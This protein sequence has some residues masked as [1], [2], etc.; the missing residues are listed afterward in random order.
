MNW[1]L[2]LYE[3]YENYAEHE[4]E[5][6]ELL[7]PVAHT[8][9]Q[10]QIEI[11]LDGKGAF[12]RASVIEK[13]S[14]VTMIPC[15]EESGG[16]AGSKPVNHPLCDKLQYVA[17]D[18]V[19]FGGD[20]TSGFASNPAEPHAAFVKSLTAWA[21]SDHGH[22][23][24]DAIR[25]YVVGGR[26]IA[27]LVKAGVLPTDKKGKL[28]KAWDGVRGSTPTIFRV[29]Q[30][31][32]APGDAFVR[33]QVESQA[34]DAVSKTWNDPT[35]ASA[36]IDYYHAIQ[37]KR[38]YCMVTG[39]EAPLAIQHPARLRG[40][41]DKAKLISSN[42]TSGFTFRGKFIKADDAAGVSFDV[43]QKAHNALRWL[44]ARQG[45]VD[46]KRKQAVVS[47]VVAVKP[48]P[49]WFSSTLELCGLDGGALE[50]APHGADTDQA[51]AIRLKK[52]IAGYGASLDPTDVV[53]VMALDSAT[54]GRMAITFYR[55]LKGSEFLDR[56]QAW[57]A[58][59]AWP[60]NMGKE[61]KFVGAPSPRDIAEAAYHRLD[62]KLGK[63]TIE[64]LLP[65]IV[66][67][68]PI[69]HALVMSTTRRASNR[70]GLENWEWEKCLGIA[71]ALFKG[72]F[73]E[74]NYQMTLETNRTTRDY[75]YG[76]LLAIAEHIESHALYV[77]GENRNT[78]A[79]RLMQRFADRPYST[80]KTIE[81]SLT[82]YKTRLRNMRAGFLYKMEKDL[83][84]VMN[85]FAAE[86]FRRDTQLSGEFLLAYHC[87][88]QVLHLRT[89]APTEN[90]PTATKE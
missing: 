89:T 20:V 85:A 31:S 78:T 87:Q 40:S 54:P 24:L 66:D 74:R 11:V 56:V 49:D 63:A 29:I 32:Q 76:R 39:K 61:R 12:R 9:Q 53:V 10:A 83:D 15:T 43:S 64:R 90:E 84:R 42:D 23:K 79:A 19:K 50:V 72:Y 52:A 8:T 59:C 33:W 27:D 46:S 34:G 14:G 65:C 6:A 88:R 5:G 25:K 60:Q 45:Y 2:K 82:P 71:C 73:T 17:A 18:F 22:P 57:H 26:V 80:W 75:L 58:R 16:R 4:P 3:T 48:H 35:L 86:D 38:G 37:T 81:L 36:W 55:E 13:G 70:V 28:L 47:W 68:L 1:L 7:M 77:A 69:P 51:F 21:K 44:I 67:G 41:G 30:K 62:E